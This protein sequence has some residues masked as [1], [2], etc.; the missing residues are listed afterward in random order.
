[1]AGITLAT[2]AD[3]FQV[4]HLVAIGKG[5]PVDIT[6]AADPHFQVRGQGVDHRH[7]HPV[8]TTGE[9]V[10]LIGELTAGVEFGENQLYP[11]NP[12]FRVDIHRH[13]AAIVR[14]RQGAV[15]V[16]G[17]LDLTRMTGQGFVNTVVDDFLGQV[18]RTGGVGIHPR[19][20]ANGVEAV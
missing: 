1:G 5:N 15:L 18:V 11:G 14:Y 20:F 7:T 2:S 6:V 13:A 9:L 3:N 4:T 16:Q 12:L 8:Q 17:H 19:A 10:V